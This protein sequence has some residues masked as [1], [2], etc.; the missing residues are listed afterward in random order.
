MECVIQGNYCFKQHLQWS[1]GTRSIKTLSTTRE[2]TFILERNK[3]RNAG[4]K[5]H[6]DLAWKTERILRI[7]RDTDCRGEKIYRAAYLW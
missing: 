1:G 7:A 2:Y 6:R 5:A 4:N 3:R